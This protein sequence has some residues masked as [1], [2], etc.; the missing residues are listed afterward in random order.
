MGRLR[1]EVACHRKTDYPFLHCQRIP[2]CENI[3]AT[4]IACVRYGKE[5]EGV[6]CT[7]FCTYVPLTTGRRLS[8]EG[9]P[10][11]GFEV[12]GDGNQD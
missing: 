6:L 8:Y 4:G 1:K 5:G 7:L 2:G 12:A 9:K 10:H 11:V 3:K